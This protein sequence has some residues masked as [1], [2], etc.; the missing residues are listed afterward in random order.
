[1]KNRPIFMLAASMLVAL[2]ALGQGSL[3]VTHEAPG[4]MS[5]LC[6]RSVVNATVTGD[7]APTSVRVYFRAGDTGPEYYIEMAAG[8][9]GNYSAVLPAPLR[10]TSAVSVR[11]VAVAADGTMS[12]TEPA[13]VPVTSDCKLAN[14]GA[15]EFD[16]ATNTILGL[17]DAAQTGAPKGF[18]CAGIAKVVGIDQTMAPN[19]ACEE[20]RLAKSDPCFGAGG[21][22]MVANAGTGAS[23]SAAAA[24]VSGGAGLRNA[25]IIGGAAVAGAVII[26]NNNDDDREPTSRSRP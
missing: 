16:F 25:A 18:S 2:S 11:V 1:M 9:G 26:E 19:N 12:A 6:G 17:T 23:S 22:V 14:L 24:G 4:C 20:V 13:M 3:S 5:S 7:S 10:E 21:A 8:G 15:D